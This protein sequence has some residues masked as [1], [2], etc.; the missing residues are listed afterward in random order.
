MCLENLKIDRRGDAIKSDRREAYKV[1]SAH[2]YSEVLLFKAL[3]LFQENKGY[4]RDRYVFN[5]GTNVAER[6]ELTFLERK[7]DRVERGFHLINDESDAVGLF[8]YLNRH[9]NDYMFHRYSKLYRVVV[10]KENH[11]ADGSFKPSNFWEIDS[12]VYNAFTFDSLIMTS[13]DT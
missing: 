10:Y 12:S 7:N 2:K 1:V 6:G 11:I 9:K 8:R 4:Y 5:K 13:D 3:G